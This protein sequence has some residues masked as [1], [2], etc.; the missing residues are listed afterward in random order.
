[1][2]LWSIAIYKGRGHEID[3]QEACSH[4]DS[5]EKNHKGRVE[6]ISYEDSHEKSHKGRGHEVEAYPRGQP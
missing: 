5:H 4:E 2:R 1:M 3:S 6:E